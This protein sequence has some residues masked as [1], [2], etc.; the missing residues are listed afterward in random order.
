[1]IKYFMMAAN[2]FKEY[3]ILILWKNCVIYIKSVLVFSSNVFLYRSEFGTHHIFLLLKLRLQVLY[4]TGLCFATMPWC[5]HNVPPS[6][7]KLPLFAASSQAVRGR[8]F[9]EEHLRWLSIQHVGLLSMALVFYTISQ[10]M[11]FYLSLK[12]SYKFHVSDQQ[13]SA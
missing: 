6:S 1:M 11:Y 10:T 4:T 7:L 2:T 12:R 9:A 13:F 5:S 8:V 3:K